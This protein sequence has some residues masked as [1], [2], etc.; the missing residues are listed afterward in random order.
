MRAFT[1]YARAIPKAAEQIRAN[2]ETPLP[3]P[4]IRIAHTNF[5]GLAGYLANDVPGV[6]AE[7]QDAGLRAE[8]SEANDAAVKALK[9]LDAWF[10]EQ[11]A[12][13][14]DDFALGAE[15]F[16]EMVRRA[17][18][19]DISLDRLRAVAE[20]DLER[21]RNA[22]EETCAELAPGAQIADCIA[23]VT[24]QKPEGDVV[25]AARKQLVDLRAFLDTHPLVTIPGSEQAKVDESPPHQRWNFAYIDIPG[26]YERALPSVYYISPPDPS[27]P[28]KEQRDYLPGASD[29]LF[30]SVHEVWPGHFLHYMHAKRGESKFGQAFQSYS[31]SEGWAHYAEEMMWDAGL[32]DGDPAIHLGQLLNALLRDARFVSAVGLHTGGMTIADSE[33]VFTERAYQDAGTARQQAL[34]GTFDPGYLNYTLG[35]LMIR[36]LRDD[37]TSTRGGRTAW[38]EFHDK[39]LSYGGP[40]VPLVRKA[41]M[42]ETAGPAL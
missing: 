18:G 5:G 31:F 14:T 7:V 40:P 8:F 17:E 16:Q 34:R 36:K 15:R 25:E 10:T 22:V 32:G 39:L 35:K 23:K 12:A 42:G 19:L 41:M 29:L 21:N 2:L 28:P 27:W 33:R 1:N 13:A 30:T 4:F 24:G 37:W 11:E 6:F 20:E 38:R 9:E 3:R 26:P